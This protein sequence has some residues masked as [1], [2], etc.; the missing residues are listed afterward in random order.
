MLICSPVGCLGFQGSPSLLLSECRVAL[1]LSP[2]ARR[3]CYCRA[4]ASLLGCSRLKLDCLACVNFLSSGLLGFPR[5]AV[6]VIV[7]VSRH[8]GALA[9]S[10]PSLLL[11]GCRVVDWVLSPK[12]RLPSLCLFSLQ[13]A[14]WVSKVCRHCYYR[15]VASL[16][17]SRL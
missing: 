5:L 4:V 17:C 7:R 12:T 10:S 3:H 2:V 15:G 6:T 11:S 1:V 16:W 9:R 8:S 13:W 14:A